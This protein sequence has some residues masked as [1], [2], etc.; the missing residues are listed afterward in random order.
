VTDEKINEVLSFWFEEID[1][2]CWFK[3]NPEF[4]QE[5]ERRFGALLL[6]AKNDDLFSWRDT[7]A[8][9][10]AHIVVLDQ[11]SRNIH[12]GS[13][14]AFAGDP[15]A[16]QLCLAGIESGAD[17]ELTPERRSFF[18]LPLRHAENLEMQELGLTKTREVNAE[19]YGSDKYALN[20]LEIIKRFDRFPHRNA[21]L[22][23]QNTSGEESYLKDG[24]AGF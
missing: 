2:S 21:V 23:R 16:L 6:R 3:V 9:R 19:G 18:Y 8:G 11:F 24:K 13:P 5:L 17:K 4:D 22:G 12:R 1:H 15:K 7:A 10:L 14:L 20:H